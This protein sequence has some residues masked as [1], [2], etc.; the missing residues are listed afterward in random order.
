M[1]DGTPVWSPAGQHGAG[2]TPPGWLGGLPFGTRILVPTLHR[3]VTIHDRGDPGNYFVNGLPHIDVYSGWDCS[4][5]G[6]FLGKGS[7]AERVFV[8]GR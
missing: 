1:A 3:V 7:H 2:A 5:F 6:N 4:L 8:Y